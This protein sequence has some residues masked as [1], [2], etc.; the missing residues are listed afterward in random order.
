MQRI[1]QLYGENVPML[2]IIEHPTLNRFTNHL[3]RSYVKE[4]A[5]APKGRG[6]GT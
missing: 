1:Q 4:E 6:R 2:A 3:L 5:A